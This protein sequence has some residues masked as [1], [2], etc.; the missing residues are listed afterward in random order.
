M[1]ILPLPNNVGR[2]FLSPPCRGH[3]HF[4][5]VGTYALF[6]PDNFLARELLPLEFRLDLV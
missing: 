5:S 3:C 6:I 2:F 1:L 4:F